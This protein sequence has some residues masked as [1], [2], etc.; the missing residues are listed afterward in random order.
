MYREKI[1]LLAKGK[2]Q[3][4]LLSIAIKHIACSVKAIEDL[5]CNKCTR[6]QQIHYEIKPG[7][8]QESIKPRVSVLRILVH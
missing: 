3:I 8:C 2:W 6:S 7:S 5:L 4:E 1:L